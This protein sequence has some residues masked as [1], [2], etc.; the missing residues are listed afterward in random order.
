M[1]KLWWVQIKGIN[2]GGGYVVNADTAHEAYEIVVS[3][4]DNQYYLFEKPE[5]IKIK[6]KGIVCGQC[7]AE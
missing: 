5:E 7:Y 1:S 3:E 2:S 4:E 6:G